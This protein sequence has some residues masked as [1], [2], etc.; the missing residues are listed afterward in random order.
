MYREEVLTQKLLLVWVGKTM[1]RES[2]EEPPQS[3]RVRPDADW[4]LL[5]PDAGIAV[6]YFPLLRNPKVQGVD[7]DTSPYLSTWNFIYS[8]EEIDKV[9]ALARTNFDAG[10]DQTKRTV[11]AVYERKK[12]KRLEAEEKERIQRWKRHLREHGDYFQ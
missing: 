10:K 2:N 12:G 6:V 5:D 3:T 1:D 9:V 8:P 7:P 4:K 11:R